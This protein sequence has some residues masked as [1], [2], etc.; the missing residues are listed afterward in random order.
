[1]EM[2]KEILE[3][4]DY[5][6]AEYAYMPHLTKNYPP[7]AGCDLRLMHLEGR[8]Y[9]I[10]CLINVNSRIS[11]VYA[12]FYENHMSFNRF[13]TLLYRY[14]GEDLEFTIKCVN[15]VMRIFWVIW[16]TIINDGNF[17]KTLERGNNKTI[18]SKPS[19]F[20]HP[21]I[22]REPGIIQIINQKKDKINS[23][24]IVNLLYTILLIF[25][26]FC[27]NLDKIH[28]SKKLNVT[29]DFFDKTIIL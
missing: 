19:E 23:L 6:R 14:Y 13:L 21:R 10:E 5:L 11:E 9:F 7:I 26:M 27:G 22:K 20:R 2:F 1:M 25:L 15:I 12:D 18:T 16:F 29:Y 4:S 8:I 24:S 17:T 3:L 28:I